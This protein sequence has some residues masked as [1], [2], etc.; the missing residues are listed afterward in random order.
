MRECERPREGL[1]RVRC[2]RQCAVVPTRAV[3]AESGQL[4]SNLTM[5]P[6]DPDPSEEMVRAARHLAA[7]WPRLLTP[8]GSRARPDKK[9]VEFDAVRDLAKGLNGCGLRSLADIQPRGESKPPTPPDVL[10]RNEHGGLVGIEVSELADQEVIE[11]N[12][13]RSKARYA[14]MQRAVT[15]DE[16]AEAKNRNPEKVRLW[17]GRQFL[18][19]VAAIIG[20]KDAKTFAVAGE[21][22]AERWLVIHTAE[23]FVDWTEFRAEL[24]ARIFAPAQLDHVYLVRDYDPSTRSYPWWQIHPRDLAF[25]Q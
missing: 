18:D 6:N 5:P 9:F 15:S 10:A 20:E 13:P 14:A 1:G 25:A 2:E 3:R 8:G 4:P 17:S 19:A 7:R 21:P 12:I 11:M 24:P 22:Y 23:P 16:R